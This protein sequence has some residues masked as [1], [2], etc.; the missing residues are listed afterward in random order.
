MGPFEQIH[1]DLIQ[2]MKSGDTERRDTLR[3]L[4]SALKNESIELHKSAAELAESDVTAIV[5]RLCKQRRES[6]EG[7]RAGGRADLAEKEERE[8][9]I[10][11]RYLPVALSDDELRAI[12]T[13][14]KSE[15]GASTKADFGKLMGSAV[16]KAAGRADG[17]AIKKFVEEAL[18]E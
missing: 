1:A 5:R 15:T 16:K 11:E 8:L 9:A 12:V 2:S 4:E 7:Y 18:S 14:A 17:N 3:M 6:A 13:D 10:L